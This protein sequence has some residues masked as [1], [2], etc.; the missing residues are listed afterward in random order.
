MWTAKVYAQWC[1][2]M[3]NYATSK[4]KI[5]VLAIVLDGLLFL[6]LKRW[7]FFS[8][9]RVTFST[10]WISSI[11]LFCSFF[12]LPLFLC[13]SPFHYFICS[14]TRFPSV[15]PS[16][17]ASFPWPDS[18][19][20]ALSCYVHWTSG[21]VN[22]IYK[23]SI[24]PGTLQSVTAVSLIKILLPPRLQ[25]ATN[26]IF[27]II[28]KKCLFLSAISPGSGDPSFSASDSLAVLLAFY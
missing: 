28:S 1:R 11:P 9:I 22:M 6:R 13:L 15:S 3:S 20:T 5:N 19:L 27:Y 25:Q 8:H 12:Y 18:A 2:N 21:C 17:E 26:G 24:T 23:D 14:F 10:S 7:A 4:M 16:P